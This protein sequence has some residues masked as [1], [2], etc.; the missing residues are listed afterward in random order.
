MKAFARFAAIHAEGI[1]E[2]MEY[3]VVAEVLCAVCNVD[4]KTCC[5]DARLSSGKVAI[6]LDR[7]TCEFAHDF[8]EAEQVAT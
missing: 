2:H 7:N 4:E 1:I 6:Y 8:S 3:L 5:C